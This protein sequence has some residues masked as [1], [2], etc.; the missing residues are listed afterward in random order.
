MQLTKNFTLLRKSGF[1]IAGHK[2]GK[3]SSI[4]ER[5]FAMAWGRSSSIILRRSSIWKSIKKSK[6]G[7]VSCA[8]YKICDLLYDN[9][10]YE[11]ISN[12]EKGTKINFIPN[13]ASRSTVSL[14]PFTSKRCF[15]VCLQNL[16]VEL[17]CGFT[18]D[19]KI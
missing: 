18:T 9:R 13:I 2:Y 3:I 6:R 15:L 5:P 11:A 12:F 17:Y 14:K 8:T 1:C 10:S 4:T 19:L 16:V 7:N